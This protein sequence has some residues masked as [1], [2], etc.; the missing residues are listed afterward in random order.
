[1]KAFK[2]LIKGDKKKSEDDT[3]PHNTPP[4][5]PERGSVDNKNV[6]QS[7]HARP[8]SV[9]EKI[10]IFED[11]VAKV[12]NDEEWAKRNLDKDFEEALVRHLAK[13][14]YFLD[15]KLWRRI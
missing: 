4:T 5:S 6:A 9:G 10:G 15:H 14:S 2:A 3:S 1:M 8:T 12:P 11:L 13:F 7:A